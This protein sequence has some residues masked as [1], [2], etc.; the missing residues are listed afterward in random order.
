Y[1]N[2][3]ETIGMIRE[4]LKI[5]KDALPAILLYTSFEES[6]LK[7]ESDEKYAKYKIIK[8]AKRNEIYNVLKNIDETQ[9]VSIEK[10]EVKLCPI[11][12]MGK[13]DT[14]LI[15]DD[16]VMNIMLL[17][18]MIENILP[19]S[20]VIEAKNGK[21]AIDKVEDFNPDIIFMDIQMPI[22]DGYQATKEIREYEIT[23]GKKRI[24]IIALTAASV[25]GERE[26][27]EEAGMDDYLTKPI[28][29]S[30]LEET[31]K[32]YLSKENDGDME[33]NLTTKEEND[34]DKVEKNE[35]FHFEKDKLMERVAGNS[36]LFKNMIE[37]ALLQWELDLE[38]LLNYIK[39][40]DLKQIKS[41]SHKIKGSA[42]TM[43][44]KKLAEISKEIEIAEDYDRIK[45]IETYDRLREELSVLKKVF[46]GL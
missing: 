18:T 22:K 8:P 7:K 20:V 2:G 3:L 24:P 46:N 43:E 32:K 23:K 13:E 1:L 5:Q 29:S 41:F 33:S 44:C 9:I 38:N 11:S 14:I 4:K 27:C 30:V 17:K 37:V 12:R 25:K 31:I 15:A 10:K 26:R 34:L 19:C 40:E 6:F 39:I 21:E 45:M 28:K 42:L 35:N 36:T 16:V